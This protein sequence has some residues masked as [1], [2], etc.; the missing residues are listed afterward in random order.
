MPQHTS[1]KLNLALVASPTIVASCNISRSG[2]FLLV[3]LLGLGVVLVAA[4]S[5]SNRLLPTWSG[6][7]LPAVGLWIALRPNYP[8]TTADTVFFVLATGILACA[9]YVSHSKSS[10]L[11]SLHLG[12]GILL[13]TA[14]AVRVLGVSAAN[15]GQAVSGNIITGGERVLFALTGSLVQGPVLAAVYLVAAPA[16]L[17]FTRQYR[18]LQLGLIAPSTYVLV[19]SDRRSA[20]F[21]T[22]FLIASVTMT[23]RLLRRFAPALVG[24]AITIPTTFGLFQELWNS[25]GTLNLAFALQREGEKANLGGR[26]GIWTRAMNFYT[27]RTDWLHQMFGFGTNGPVVSGA[28]S[29]YG[30]A[31]GGL[32]RDRILRTPHNSAIQLLFDGGWIATG[33][34]VIAVIYAAWLLSR[35]DSAAYLGGLAMITAAAGVGMTES[36]LSPSIGSSIWWTL[37]LIVTIALSRESSSSRDNA[38]GRVGVGHSGQRVINKPVRGIT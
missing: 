37:L 1:I 9:V 38:V 13:T 10:A 33:S 35:C 7:V 25:I 31:F 16:L 24:F 30:S 26:F 20:L 32:T 4:P 15:S 34:F 36:V 17:R 2:S 22:L 5:T 14:V 29:T 3:F 18:I 19:Q 21:V 28:S 12:V 11:I 27:D 23:P 8:N 6:A